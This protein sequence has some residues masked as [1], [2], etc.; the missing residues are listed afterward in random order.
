MSFKRHFVP[1][2]D[3]KQWFTTTT[4]ITFCGVDT[5]SN[6]LISDIDYNVIFI[7]ERNSM[8]EEAVSDIPKFCIN[9]KFVWD[10]RYII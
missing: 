1:K 8:I 6:V 5:K 7:S 3:V 4:T 2:S 10:I 9:I